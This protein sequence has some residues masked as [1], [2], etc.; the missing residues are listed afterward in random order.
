MSK[1]APATA[2][3]LALLLAAPAHARL[4][5]V[6]VTIENL[7]GPGSVSFA[8]LRFGFNRGVFDAFN[9]G[10]VATAPIISVAEGGSGTDWFPAFAAA[11]PTAVLGSV[12]MALT[13]GQTRTS[14]TFRVDTAV[15]RYFTFG[16]MVVPSNDHFIGNDDP[17]EYR[18]FNVA[19]DLLI[20]TIE[21][22]ASEI[23]NAG[24]E[25]TDPL[26]AAFLQ[27][28][29]NDLRTPEGGVVRFEFGELSAFNGLT[30]A[31]GYVFNN[32]LA[33]DDLIY[34]ITFNATAVPAPAGLALLG[35]GTLALRTVVR[36][37]RA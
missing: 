33:A 28:G 36:R 10:G 31:A 4:V 1:F 20:S 22:R 26:N 2:A 25:A 6:T 35:L 23:W 12:P 11:E 18:I 17:L 37:R 30:T 21:Q 5:D 16:S 24:S 34:R 7:A 8:P 13:P 27:I 32:D 19:G 14:A 29:N 3:A 9:E 15:N